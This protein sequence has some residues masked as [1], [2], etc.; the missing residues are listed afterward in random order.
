VRVTLVI[1]GLGG[2]GAERVC[3]NL[4]NAWSDHRHTTILTISQNKRAPAYTIDPRVHLLDLGW[5]RRAHPDEFNELATAPLLRLLHN[6]RCPQLIP[7][8][9]ILA[10]LRHAILSTKPDVVVSFIDRTN[11]RVLAAMAETSVPIVATEQTDARR[12][13]LGKWQGAREELYRRA[14]AVI[15]PD[16]AIAHWLATKG[17][18]AHAIA[19]PLVA[20]PMRD[21]RSGIP[22]HGPENS[23]RKIITLSRLSSEKRP[24]FL[25]R[26]FA[27]IA[28]DF[29]EWDLDL[30]GDGPQRNMLEHLIEKLAPNRVRICGFSNDPYGVL[31]SA[32]VFVSASRIEG[33]GNAIWE[34]LACGVPVVAMDAGPPVR[35]L[36]RHGIDGVIVSRNTMAAL[37]GALAS[38]MRDEAQRKAYA[39]R[40]PE[41]VERFPFESA[42]EQWDELFRAISFSYSST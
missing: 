15:A 28:P 7:E 25:V 6:A 34:A 37:A 42:L 10:M 29:P 24:E 33:F 3:I 30:Y 13:S 17:A 11:V 22:Q 5:P 20:P 36:V 16:P 41:V 9:S 27:S 21:H 8:L 1:A 4:A 40:A 2:G 26:S 38:L 31:A 39:S 32:D 35:A 12:I 18:R 23:G 19:N 14:A